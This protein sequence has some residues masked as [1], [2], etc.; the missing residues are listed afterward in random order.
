MK[1]LVLVSLIILAPVFIIGS[2]GAFEANNI[3]FGQCFIQ[4]A[5]AT[6]VGWASIKLLATK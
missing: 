6:I 2:V 4:S 5:I 1:N 3:G